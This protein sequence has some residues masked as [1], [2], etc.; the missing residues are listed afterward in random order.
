MDK[1][2][3]VL[4][5]IKDATGVLVLHCNIFDKYIA[6][7]I[8]KNLGRKKNWQRHFDMF[9]KEVKESAKA[10]ENLEDV[11]YRLLGKFIEN[12][13]YKQL[14]GSNLGTE[15]TRYHVVVLDHACQAN[16]S[17]VKLEK[18]K[19]VL[20]SLVY[21]IIHLLPSNP[22]SIGVPKVSLHQMTLIHL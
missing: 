10:N 4:V 20:N 17:L 12:T 1:R 2:N 19:G 16:M 22:P 6:Q 3:H 7:K 8:G 5:Q 14:A 9:N 21:R 18:F 15:T 11:S 13:K